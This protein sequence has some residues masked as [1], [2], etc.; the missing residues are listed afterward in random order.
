LAI[1][2]TGALALLDTVTNPMA[3]ST[4]AKLHDGY[5]YVV[6]YDPGGVAVWSTTS[7]MLTP[8]PGTPYIGP[9]M[10]LSNP[11]LIGFSQ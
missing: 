10:K 9:G 2:S 4:D 6:D 7:G 11:S 3:P 5:L 8:E 1:A